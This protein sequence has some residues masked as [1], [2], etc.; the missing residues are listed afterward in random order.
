MAARRLTFVFAS[1]LV[2]LGLAAPAHAQTASS[3][4]FC[5]SDAAGTLPPIHRTVEWA[6][7]GHAAP[8]VGC[9]SCHGGNPAATRALE[10]HRGVL[11][12][13]SPVSTINEVNLP[14]T[15]VSCHRTTAV[16]V[17]GTIHQI[18]A[19]AGDMRTPTCVTCH[20]IGVSHVPAPAEMEQQCA[21]CHRAG[22]RRAA[23]PAAAREVLD[24]IASLRASAAA[25][26]AEIATMSDSGRRA[27]LTARLLD[28]QAMLKDASA[29]FH[30]FRP[31]A[32]SSTLDGIRQRLADL[33]DAHPSAQR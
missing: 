13:T 18:L 29:A 32:M 30:Q 33:A 16:A 23:Y 3:C 20:G 26:G 27:E 8:S 1:A 17:S 12:S 5:H 4:T 11:R 28:T 2:A 22:S 14:S 31:A 19:E 7:S 9:Q 10:A 24:A 21:G 6:A 15:C 25:L